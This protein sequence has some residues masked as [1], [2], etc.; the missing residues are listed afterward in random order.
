MIRKTGLLAFALGVPAAVLRGMEIM[1]AYDARTGMPLGASWMRF[2]VWGLAVLVLVLAVLSSAPA[3]NCA[4]PYETLFSHQTT[5]SKTGA[6]A[7]AGVM[8]IGGVAG[9]AYTLLSGAMYRYDALTGTYQLDLTTAI[10][11][12]GL[13]VLVLCTVAS[14]IV[15]LRVRHK[16]VTSK[17]AIFAVIP[18]YWAAFDLIVTF[19]ETSISPFVSRYLIDL[20]SAILLMVAFYLHAAM[21]YGKPRVRLHLIAAA[22]GIFF[23]VT[24]AG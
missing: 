4:V 23:A 18:L 13:W 1:H 7:A 17:G 19:K 12:L 15:L 9:L 5:L 20:V 22:L 24:G 16:E 6:V 21:L 11:L 2:G 8:L 10:P 14:F 3:Q